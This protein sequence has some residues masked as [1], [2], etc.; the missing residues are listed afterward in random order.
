[1]GEMTGSDSQNHRRAV[2]L[3][4]NMIT[5]LALFA[6]F[7]SVVSSLN[8]EFVKAAVAILVAGLFDAL[9]GRIARLTRTASPFGV[10]YDSLSDLVAFGMAPAILMY[11]AVLKPLGRFGWLGAFLYL[12]CG[13]LRLARFNVQTQKSGQKHFTGLP[14][15]AAAGVVAS[16]LLLVG[17]EGLK[18]SL[19]KVGV[20]MGVYVLSLLMVSRIPYPGLKQVVIPRRKAFQVLAGVVICLVIAANYPEKFLFGFAVFY[21]VLGPVF[22]AWFLRK[23]AGGEVIHMESYTLED[24]DILEGDEEEV[25]TRNGA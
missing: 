23:L 7:F 12:A 6:G 19:I 21:T 13:A 9:D 20:V 1:M 8:G 5:S 11:T 14:I 2:Y 22:G 18:S 4:P 3:L 25:V 17:S 16:G 15:P 24:E 10:Q